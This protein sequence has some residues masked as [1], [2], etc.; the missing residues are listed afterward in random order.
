MTKYNELCNYAAKHGGSTRV[1]REHNPKLYDWTTRQ[2]ELHNLLDENDEVILDQE[3]I[4]L[5]D[6]IFF[7]WYRRERSKKTSRIEAK[8]M[9]EPEGEVLQAFDYTWFSLDRPYGK[10]KYRMVMKALAH[11]GLAF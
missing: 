5:L 7:D 9:H 4:D 10:L 11:F 3:K 2:R 1:K 8:F 6:K